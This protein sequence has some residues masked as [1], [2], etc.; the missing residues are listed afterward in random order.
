MHAKIDAWSEHEEVD[1]VAVDLAVPISCHL[2]RS[3]A[4]R[5]VDCLWI[6]E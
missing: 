5:K 4:T 2:L 1:E 6:F 3:E